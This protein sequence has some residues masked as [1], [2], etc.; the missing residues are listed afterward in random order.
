MFGSACKIATQVEYLG[1]SFP[2]HFFYLLFFL[3]FS[4]F[5]P[6]FFYPHFQK[7]PAI[8]EW[9]IRILEWSGVLSG[10]FE[11]VAGVL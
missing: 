5:S 2:I 10:V 11:K 9:S 3:F 6:L 8:L 7:T 4:L 1:V